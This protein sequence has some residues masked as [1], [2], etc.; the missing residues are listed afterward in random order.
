MPASPSILPLTADQPA[1]AGSLGV[2][3]VPLPGDYDNATS[4]CAER[5]DPLAAELRKPST[6]NGMGIEFLLL[7]RLMAANEGQYRGGW[8]QLGQMLA[9]EG[10]TVKR[11]AVKLEKAGRITM[12]EI[13]SKVVEIKLCGSV[14]VRAQP[15]AGK[16]AGESATADPE[17]DRLVALYKAAK[18]AGCITRLEIVG[19]F[20]NETAR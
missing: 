4:G 13:S 20:G 10:R 8:D 5:P 11:W 3:P 9:T 12:N 7:A 18:T 17:L 6:Y 2:A 1:E 14:P 16:P 15:V 19:T